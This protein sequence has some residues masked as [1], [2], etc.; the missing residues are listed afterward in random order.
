MT[1]EQAWDSCVTLAIGDK[2]DG[3]KLKRAETYAKAMNLD[4]GAMTPCEI[5]VT[6][7]TAASRAA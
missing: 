4:L 3:F 2:V 7:E 6:L 5:R 1:A